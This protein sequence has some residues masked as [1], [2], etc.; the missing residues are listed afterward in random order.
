MGPLL[1]KEKFSSNYIV[2]SIKDYVYE[3]SGPSSFTTRR[4]WQHKIVK[5]LGFLRKQYYLLNAGVQRFSL[6]VLSLI[7]YLN[8]IGDKSLYADTIKTGV[9]HPQVVVF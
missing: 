6:V 7:E 1:P 4:K 5:D 2:Q 3:V 8:K 9:L